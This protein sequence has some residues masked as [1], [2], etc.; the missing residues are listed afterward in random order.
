[1]VFG[2]HAFLLYEKNK[3]DRFL[4]HHV[5]RKALFLIWLRYKS[6][7]EEKR[8]MWVVP[9]EVVKQQV[10][11]REELRLQY[12]DVT[13]LSGNEIKLKEEKDI[14]ACTIRVVVL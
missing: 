11:Y 13:Y 4:N 2:W 7:Y 3:I 14:E 1:M 10:N 6:I 9:L 12:K 8:P 5:I